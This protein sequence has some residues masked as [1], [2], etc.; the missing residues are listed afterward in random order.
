[1]R[2]KKIREKKNKIRQKTIYMLCDL[3][4]FISTKIQNRLNEVVAKFKINNW[5]MA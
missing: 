3:F 4:I 5:K 2:D 1:L